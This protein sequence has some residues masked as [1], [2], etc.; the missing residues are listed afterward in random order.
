MN[1]ANRPAT[2]WRYTADKQTYWESMRQSQKLYADAGNLSEE[3]RIECEKMLPTEGKVSYRFDEAGKFTYE[4]TLDDKHLASE[5]ARALMHYDIRVSECMESQA[6]IRLEQI[7]VKFDEFK[8]ELAFTNPELAA[9][10]FGFV[11][12]ELGYLEATSSEELSDEEA[13][14]ISGRL[15]DFDDLRQM[16]LGHADYIVGMCKIDTGMRPRNGGGV[17]QT[18]TDLTRYAEVVTLKTIRKFV[19]Y[20]LLLHNPGSKPGSGYSWREQLEA[21]GEKVLK[22]MAAAKAE[23]DAK[24]A[25]VIQS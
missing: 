1:I 20:G 23:A 4:S 24:K 22:E 17:Q 21:N 19:D 12:N 9:K 14:L 7:Q 13:Q 15:N 5:V 6:K 18:Q 25:A 10:K 11:I 3:R 2:N 16:L 8:N